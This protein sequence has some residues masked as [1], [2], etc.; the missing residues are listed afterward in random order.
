MPRMAAHPDVDLER[1]LQYTIKGIAEV[2][3]A[4]FT[5]G[6]VQTEDCRRCIYR[7]SCKGAA[8]AQ[9]EQRPGLRLVPFETLGPVAE[10]R[11]ADP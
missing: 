1:P 3:R 7:L 11:R 10:L 5:Q 8:R 2:M 4:Y 9:L 6:L